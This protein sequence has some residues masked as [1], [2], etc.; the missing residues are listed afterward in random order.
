MFP[1]P[2]KSSKN[3]TAA[4]PKESSGW[5]VY[6][7]RCADDS[8]YTGCTNNLVRR[9]DR[10]GKGRV[11]YTRGRL[12]V[13]V[14]YSEPA[15]SHGAALRREAAIKRLSRTRKLQLIA[16]TTQRTPSRPAGRGTRTTPAVR[17]RKPPDPP[18]ATAQ[19]ASRPGRGERA[20]ATQP[21]RSRAAARPAGS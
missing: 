15:D 5:I 4:Q 16:A 19:P 3:A 18:S 1:V 20:V 12:P 9:L 10:H 21:V 7:L 13:E 6:I 14:A 8:L 11:K 2:A 17:S